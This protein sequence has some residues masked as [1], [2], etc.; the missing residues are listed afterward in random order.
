MAEGIDAKGTIT[1]VRIMAGDVS[2][3]NFGFDITPS[4]LVTGLITER[5]IAR[6]GIKG[7]SELFPDKIP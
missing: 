2:V 6:E 7:I 1:S 4:R 5:G 3:S